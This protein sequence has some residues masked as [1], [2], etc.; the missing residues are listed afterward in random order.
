MAFADATTPRTV[1]AAGLRMPVT[2]K[3]AATILAGDVITYNSGW[4]EAA[5]DTASH[6]FVALEC[7][8]GAEIIMVS[9][10]AY[11]SSVTGATAG[12][13]VYTADSGGYAASGT[14]KIGVF[15]SDTE[16]YIGPT[17]IPAT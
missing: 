10:S 12:A 3:A 13:I 2:L 6:V 7:G 16:M 4:T 5:N 14:K 9:E 15:L 8:V 11:V 17:T 1:H